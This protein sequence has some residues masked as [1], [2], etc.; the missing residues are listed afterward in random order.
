MK[1]F[2]LLLVM[3]FVVS[4]AKGQIIDFEN[5]SIQ[6]GNKVTNQFCMDECCVTF[7]LGEKV[8]P[9]VYNIIGQPVLA[10][11]G[12]PK[13]AF[14]GP[15]NTTCQDYT[16]DDMISL[17]LPSYVVG[18]DCYF[19]TDGIG[20]S[21][22]STIKALIIEYASPSSKTSGQILDIDFTADGTEEI[23]KLTAF[24][25]SGGTF[26]PVASQTLC[27]SATLGGDGG[28]A[29]FAFNSSTPF[30]RIVV[31]Y[32]G[33]KQNNI[34]LGFD[35]F[36]I[37]SINTPCIANFSYFFNIAYNYFSFTA[38]NQI[39]GS[40]DTW[41]FGDGTP[42]VNG[43]QVY[44]AYTQAGTYQVCLLVSQEDVGQCEECFSICV[45]EEQ[46]QD[47]KEK[48]STMPSLSSKIDLIQN[49]YPNPAKEQITLEVNPTRAGK[50]KLIIY[51][52]GGRKII[53]NTYS[54][55]EGFQEITQHLPNILKGIYFCKTRMNGE[56]TIIKFLVK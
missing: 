9:G 14:K 46:I 16:T 54:L 51:G 5:L 48:I 34:G 37:C 29:P 10:K 38:N 42:P 53:S 11:V 3:L 33:T 26:I 8:S 36:S 47:E 44:H 2:N 7:Y 52:F 1:H 23:W 56:S 32:I 24:Q 50:A 17:T 13:I 45:T 21:E 25:N 20:L 40:S 30:D 28:T 43:S 35:N 19:L 6:E 41:D 55:Q 12:S 18:P 39:G 27:P 4:I 15:L 31:E 49:F 22:A